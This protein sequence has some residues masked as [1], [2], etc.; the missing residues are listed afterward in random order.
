M[1]RTN[2]PPNKV[3]FN[4]IFTLLSECVYGGKIDNAFDR[5]LLNTFLKQLFSVNSFEN[6]FKLVV[7]EML[8][9]N[10]PEANKREQF[11]EWV[12]N[13]KHQQTPSWLGL[14]NS[15]EKVLLSNYC[16]EIINKLLKL[17][18]MDEE[19][20]ELAY[21]PE[22]VKQEVS[23]FKDNK[24]SSDSRPLWIR[25]LHHSVNEWLSILPKNLQSIRR[26]QENIRDPLF[27]FFEREIKSGINLLKTVLNDLNDVALIC[28]GEKKQTNHHRQL[29]KDLAK[30]LIPKN[31]RRYT[32]PKNLIVQPWI[33][34]FAERVKQLAGIAKQ[35]AEQGLPCLK[36]CVVWLGGLFTPE[37]YITA[38]RQYVAQTNSWSL[39]ELVLDVSVYENVAQVKLD[40]HC[41]GLTGL[42][43]QGAVC[44]SNKISLSPN[45]LNSFNIAVIKWQK[46]SPEIQEAMRKKINLPIYLNSTRSELL[47]TINME[48]DQNENSFFM[49]GVAILAS[50]LGG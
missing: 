35:F 17:S 7:D 20:E 23:I 8:Q 37:A 27:R 9:L 13:L 46:S 38:T 31:W 44:H 3:P 43:L 40:Q 16:H 49:R 10:M 6:E 26:T 47:F 22:P 29:L 21:E 50:N 28:D 39:E 12:E 15:A 1:G 42:K 34:D 30:G 25:Q 2:L 24:K 18:I 45:I 48:A 11:V 14:P 41:F 33:V 5:R 32:V 36:E 19:E 4:A